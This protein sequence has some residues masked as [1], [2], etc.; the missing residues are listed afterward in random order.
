MKWYD[1]IDCKIQKIIKKINNV[2]YTILI[3]LYHISLY[4]HNT[5]SEYI[6]LILP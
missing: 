3:L 5:N 6:S 1:I 2:N 4:Q